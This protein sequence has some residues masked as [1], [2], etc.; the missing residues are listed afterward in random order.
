MRFLFSSLL[1]HKVEMSNM[2]A[3]S[4]VTVKSD[5]SFWGVLCAVNLYC[6]NLLLHLNILG[7]LLWSSDICCSLSCCAERMQRLT[8]INLSVF[9]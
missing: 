9:D 1:V 5:S 3:L 4:H 8:L 2:A 7:V 6:D